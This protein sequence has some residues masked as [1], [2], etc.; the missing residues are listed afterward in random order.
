M[1]TVG[2]IAEYNPFHTGHA[3]HL[4][5]AKEC[6][7]ADYAVAVM[8]P[9][10]VQRGEPAVFDKFTRAEMALR[11]GADLVIELPLCYASGS[12]EY[13]ADGAVTLLD[14]LGTVDCLCFGAE[15]A[16][17]VSS[18]QAAARMILEEP[19]AYRAALQKCLR[20]GLTF[21]QARSEAIRSSLKQDSVFPDSGSCRTDPDSLLS[22][23]NNLLGVEYCRSLLKI[24][25]SIEPI[26]VLRVGSG[27]LTRELEGTYSSAAAIRQALKEQEEGSARLLSCIPDAC[28]DLFRNASRRRIEADDFLPLLTQ[29]LLSEQH[30]EEILDISPDLA[31]RMEH[32][33]YRCIGKNFEETVSLLKTRQMTRARIRRAL[34]HLLLDI[35]TETVR[36]FQREGTVFYA[37]VLGFR[38][39][40]APLLHEIRNK[41]TLPLITKASQAPRL[42]AKKEQPA[43]KMWEQDLTASHLYRSLLT[44]KYGTPFRSEYEISP[45]IL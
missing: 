30:F 32:L 15:D 27:Y 41:G 18:F 20:Q 10:F 22:R 2:I 16:A 12:A 9:D 29:K 36:A 38:K 44:A 3:Y 14:R 8:S 45:V 11:C 42:L 43:L 40:A 31:A 37:H 4:K 34:L 26:P 19:P 21:P 39:D 5:K 35:R 13:F 33:R 7:G 1:R 28:A 6:A 23:P 25:S 24:H 17:D